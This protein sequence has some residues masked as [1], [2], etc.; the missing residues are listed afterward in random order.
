MQKKKTFRLPKDPRNF[1]YKEEV[2]NYIMA[3]EDA[4]ALSELPDNLLCYYVLD[5]LLNEVNNGGFAQYLT[6]LSATTYPYLSEAVARLENEEI[7]AL[8]RK[9]IEETEV[10]LGGRK[11]SE[12]ELSEPFEQTLHGL[13]DAFYELDEKYDIEKQALKSYKANYVE[14]KIEIVLVKERESENCRYFTVDNKPTTGEGL[15]ALFEFLSEFKDAEWELE[16]ALW[17]DMFR[18]YAYADIE[19]IDLY[20]VVRGFADESYSFKTHTMKSDVFHDRKNLT[21]FEEISVVSVEG[22]CEEYS[23]DIKRNGFEKNEYKIKRRFHQGW[24]KDSASEKKRR[25][26][27]VLGY[28][29]LTFDKYDVEAIKQALATLAPKYGCIGSVYAKEETFAWPPQERK[30]FLYER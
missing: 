1:L 24:V 18:I 30:A 17:G 6:N 23:V 5:T 14:G 22:E 26:Y 19:A 3:L 4:G 10:F 27:V 29:N 7:R 28:M 16:L 20:E 25:P 8:L 21:A 2:Y 13:D 12:T 15:V 9:F 11:L